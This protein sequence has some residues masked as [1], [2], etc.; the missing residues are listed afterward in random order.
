MFLN[1]YELLYAYVCNMYREGQVQNSKM[2]T[3]A[4]FHKKPIITGT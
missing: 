4:L 2:L 1:G 3:E